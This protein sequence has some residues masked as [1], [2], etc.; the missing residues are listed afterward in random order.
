MR[1]IVLMFVA[2]LSMTMAY[3]EGENTNATESLKAYTVDIHMGALANALHLNSDQID[4]VKDIN[5]TF[6]SEMMNVAS[7]DKADRKAELDKVVK[8]N[9]A[10]MR[11]VLSAT[12]YRTYISLLNATLNNRGLMK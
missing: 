1:K 6:S 9:L 11:Q 5:T 2:M 12:Q 4:A 8:K 10:Y 3:A 7:A